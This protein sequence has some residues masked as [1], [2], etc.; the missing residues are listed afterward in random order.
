MTE[1]RHQGS[2]K[3][4]LDGEL[5]IDHLTSSESLYTLHHYFDHF[6]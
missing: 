2:I 3:Y 6:A 5:E 1:G 4:C